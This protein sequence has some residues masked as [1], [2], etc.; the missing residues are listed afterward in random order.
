MISPMEPKADAKY[1][2]ALSG[3]KREIRAEPLKPYDSIQLGV[4]EAG[5]G[6]ASG[7]NPNS[8]YPK[9]TVVLQYPHF[10]ELGFDIGHCFPGTLNVSIAPR[11]FEIVNPWR[12]LQSVTWYEGRAPESFK[13]CLCGIRHQQFTTNGFIY[14]PD[15]KTK[16]EY[17][18]KP[19]QLQVLAP[20]IPGLD[21]GVQVELHYSSAELQIN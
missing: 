2:Y 10:K 21:Y 14:Y 15:P 7:K 17:Y 11:T 3:E 1:F 8:K 5:H 13:I 19:T 20:L 12:E 16:I 9:G 6:V 18:D 4:V